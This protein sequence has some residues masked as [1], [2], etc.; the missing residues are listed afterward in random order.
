M[1]SRTGLRDPAHSIPAA[2][3]IDMVRRA[4]RSS[5]PH[6][7]IHVLARQLIGPCTLT[8]MYEGLVIAQEK[9]YRGTDL[10][11]AAA[12]ML[13]K[14][15]F[16]ALNDVLDE[17]KARLLP[18]A[19]RFPVA[20]L[21]VT[22]IRETA[23]IDGLKKAYT[24]LEGSTVALGLAIGRPKETLDREF[25]QWTEAR[26]RSKDK[27]V[28]LMRIEAEAQERSAAGDYAGVASAM[29]RALELRPDGPQDLFNLASAEMRIKRYAAAEEHLKRILSLPL[30]PKDSRFIIFG[31]YQ[32]GRLYDVQSRREEALAEYR[33]VLELPDQKDAHRLAKEAM[34]T[35]A[36]P[37]SLE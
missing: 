23:G 26:V 35:P 25:R 22:W 11:L 8:T 20:G 37:E 28:K 33:K 14:G 34:E 30:E 29:K 12:A 32:L 7:E 36:T 17:E 5:S 13:D 18:E 24:A 27:E 21:L 6:E 16:P 9:A 4:A 15:A 31:H 1:E 2:R 3:E 10:V 19:V